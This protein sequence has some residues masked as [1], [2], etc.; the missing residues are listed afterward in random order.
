MI[1]QS[2]SNC[3][4]FQ[5]LVGL[6]STSSFTLINKY[7]LQYWIPYM[8]QQQFHSASP[9][10][11]GSSWYSTHMIWPWQSTVP[12]DHLALSFLTALPVFNNT[13]WVLAQKTSLWLAKNSVSNSFA[14]PWLIA[15]NIANNMFNPPNFYNSFRFSQIWC[16]S[17]GFIIWSPQLFPFLSAYLS[18]KVENICICWMFLS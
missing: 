8:K 5:L 11:W 7:H 15:M 1:L 16:T 9:G 3:I 13:S 2:T 10:H 4:Y 12:W 18:S 14:F 6:I 17:N